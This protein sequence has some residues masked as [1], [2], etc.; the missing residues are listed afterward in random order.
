ML[1]TRPEPGATA[2]ASRLHAAGWD[3]VVA[4]FLTV[5]RM[6]TALPRPGRLQAVVAASGN[7]VTLPAAYHTLPL[8]AVGHATAARARSAG[9]RTVRSAGGDAA[10]LA[11]LTARLLDP[12]DGPILLATGR[13]QGTALARALRRGGFLVSRR[14]VYAAAPVRRFPQPAA[15]AVVRGLH[16]ALFFSAETAHTFARR[17]PAALRPCLSRTDAAVIGQGAAEAL[18]HLP[19]RALRVAVRPTQD[20][21]LALL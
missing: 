5:R 9:F 17:L 7:A 13:G 3:P 12:A 6:A 21:V 10:A 15:D 20:E 1:V 8:L 4:P 18:R 19:W 14:A 16:A 11:T 2:T